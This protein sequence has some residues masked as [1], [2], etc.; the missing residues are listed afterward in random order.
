MQRRKAALD[1]PSH[2]SAARPRPAVRSQ[3][4]REHRIDV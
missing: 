2:S 4:Q 3:R 1:Q